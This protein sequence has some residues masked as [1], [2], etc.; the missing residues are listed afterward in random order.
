[1]QITYNDITIPFFDFDEM[2]N[3]VLLALSGGLDSASLFYLICTHF[4][5]IEIIPWNGRNV[6]APKDTEAAQNIIEWM[7]EQFP[8][9]TIQNLEVR[10]FDDQD[11]SLFHLVSEKIIDPND[12]VYFKLNEI[13]ALKVF[14]NDEFRNDLINQYQVSYSANGMTGNP[15]II[16]MQKHR[17]FLESCEA[18]R[19]ITGGD[20]FEFKTK[21]NK[22]YQPFANVDKKFIADIYRQHNLM[23]TLYPLTRSCVGDI[24]STNNFTETCKSCFWCYE[25]R[26]AFKDLYKEVFGVRYE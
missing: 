11:E 6:N 10:D 22:S 23:Q 14:K 25:K 20:S 21:E 16:E 4:P 12:H 2:P 26:W 5:E 19:T 24:I 13:Q 8:N 17:L 3:K 9:V 7:K 1:M 18:R 15:P